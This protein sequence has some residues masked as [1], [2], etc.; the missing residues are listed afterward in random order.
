[1]SRLMRLV[2]ESE[3]I[4]RAFAAF[5]KVRR[6]RSQ[7]QVKHARDAGLLYDLQLPGYED[8]WDIVVKELES[9]YQWIWDHDLE[10]DVKQAEKIFNEQTSRL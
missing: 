8:D 9:R 7:R 10:A 5:D 3:D 1:M 4:P 2:Y 6:P